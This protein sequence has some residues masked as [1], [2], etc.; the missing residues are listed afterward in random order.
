MKVF[1]PLI[2]FLNRLKYPQKFTL[3]TL[4]FVLPLAAFYPLVAQQNQ[5]IENYGA[6]EFYGTQYL[7]PLQYLLRDAQQ[8]ELIV[9]G[10]NASSV[11]L[12]QAQAQIEDDFQALQ[13]IDKQY[14]AVLQT[15]AG[16]ADLNVE[17]QALKANASTMAPSVRAE[18]QKKF[19]ADIRA[20]ISRVGDTSF[21]ILDPDLDTYYM[22]DTVL[23]KLPESQNLLAQ[24]LILGENIIQNQAMTADERTQLIIL[25]GLLKSNLSAMENNVRI[26]FRNN[27]S[28]T[29][30]TLSEA[31]LQAYLTS[32]NQFLDL[33]D[34][35]LLNA[36]T[37]NL[38]LAEFAAS[39]NEALKTNDAFY[40]A[41]SQALEGGVQA[42]RQNL[43]RLIIFA[44]AVAAGG[45]V[46]AF[47]IGLF[48]MLSISRPLS[49]LAEATQRLAM[50]EMT[51]RVAVTSGDEI[52]QVGLAFNNMAGQL[53]GAIQNLDRRAKEIATVAEVSRRLSAIL[54]QDQLVRE[55]VEQVKNAFNYYHAHIY[56]YD[57]T[58]NEL[59]MAGGTGEAGQTLLARGHKIPKGRG[60][61]GRAADT[62]TVVLVSDVS[63]NP[64]WLP[65]PLLPET[66][67]EVAV[68][69][70][71]GDQVLGV[72]DVQHNITDGLK[73]EDA[74]LLQAI[75]N[76]VAIALRNARSFSETKHR[77]DRETLIG[78]I[79]QKI[80]SAT[81]VENALQVAVLELGRALGTRTSVRL[82]PVEDH[83]SISDLPKGD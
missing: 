38:S 25:T 58:G 68:P 83:Q 10:S 54:E 53:R 4:L 67:S 26:A 62:N 8:Y 41:A 23:L 65:N 60:L 57:E 29:M 7:R 46:V 51:A 45:I 43:T 82:K 78:S 14:G 63:K 33:I 13:Q 17:W 19:I 73:Q 12:D 52:G 15:S 76:Q 74:D 39:A 81:T 66:K 64:D 20:L 36:P 37:I 30:Q 32:A 5:R 31:P 72:L 59:L 9:N 61:V 35:R 44:L 77:A 34:T 11:S 16:Q 24:T 75:A 22:M 49:N 71:I 27:P 3:I 55:V 48:L 56:L 2:A 6:K 50:G 42:R 1:S 69:I 70:S 47:V 18:R 40:D 28:G 79:N 21:L 80:Q